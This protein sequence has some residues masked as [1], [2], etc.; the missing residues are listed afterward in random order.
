MAAALYSACSGLT[1][2]HQ[3]VCAALTAGHPHRIDAL[4]RKVLTEKKVDDPALPLLI[5]VQACLDLGRK[6]QA[7][8]FLERAAAHVSN[9][10]VLRLFALAIRC[11]QTQLAIQLHASRPNLGDASPEEAYEVA[12]ETI[13][14]AKRL[15]LP[16]GRNGAWTAHLA[17]LEAAIGLLEI[18]KNSALDMPRRMEARDHLD[19]ARRMSG[20]HRPEKIP[21][22]EILAHTAMDAALDD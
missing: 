10:N 21:R 9:R 11:G 17:L 16:R 20:H 15:R 6:K 22:K 1:E 3:N 5:V 2:F 8:G 19:W 12:L 7:C 13:A 4:C 14:L 18:V